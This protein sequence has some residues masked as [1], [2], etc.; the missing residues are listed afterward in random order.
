MALHQNIKLRL[1]TI[2]ESIFEEL[3][4]CVYACI[5]NIYISYRK[6]EKRLAWA[7]YQGPV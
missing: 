1:P 4:V 2:G 3:R 7:I 5:H 6:Q